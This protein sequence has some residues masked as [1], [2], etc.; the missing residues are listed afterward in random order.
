MRLLSFLVGALLIS[1]VIGCK[2]DKASCEVDENYVPDLSMLDFHADLTNAWWTTAT[3]GTQFIYESAD[4]HIVVEIKGTQQIAGVTV[5]AF[6]DTVTAIDG[7]DL[8]ED[9]TDYYAEDAAGNIWYFGE[10]TAE[11]ENGEVVST[12]GSWR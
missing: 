10:D 5:R 3:Q 7:G 9:T 8:I 1:F 4:E 12:A 6:Q 2:D 11:Y